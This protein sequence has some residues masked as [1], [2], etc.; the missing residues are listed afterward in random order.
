[1]CN[2]KNVNFGTYGQPGQNRSV[3]CTP[4]GRRQYIDNC[5]LPELKDLWQKDIKT[6][7]SCCGHNKTNG[8]I[9]VENEFIKQMQILGYVQEVRKEIFYPKSVPITN[10]F[11]DEYKN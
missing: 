9:S 5:I 2:C 11:K 4:Q 3:V 6:T 7:E 10:K 1:M 8:Y